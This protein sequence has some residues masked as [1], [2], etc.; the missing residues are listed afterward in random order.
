MPTSP[1]N[2]RYKT[3]EGYHD[4][5]PLYTGT[6]MPL[7]PNLVFN[8]TPTTSE[9][10]AN[11]TSDSEDESEIE[12]VPKQKEYN[13]ILTSK[14]VKTPRASVKPVEH[15]KQ[16]ETLMTD[17]QQSRGHKNSWN[18]KACFV[19]K[20]LNH[21]IKDYD[22]YE[23]QMGNPQQAIKD[24]GVIDNGCSR[25][26]TGNIYFLLD[27]EEINGG[28][29]AFGGNPKGGKI[30]GKGKIKTGKLDFDDV[31]FV[32]ELMFNLFSVSQMCDK[33]NNVLFTNTE[34][35]VLS[36]DYKVPDEN[37]VLLRVPRE[38]NMYNVDLKNVVPSRDLTCLFAK[39]TLDE[40]NIWH[41]RLGHI[42][43]KTMNKLV[44]GNLVRGLPSKIFENHHTCVACKKGRQH[45][46]S[47]IGPK[48]LF[49][50]DTL[51]KSMNY[52]PVVAGNQPNNHA[53][54]KENID[55]G[56][57][58]NNHACIKENI[59]AGKVGKET[60]FAQQY[61][62]LPLWS[63]SSQDPQNID[64][65]AFDV[66]ENENDVYVSPRVRD[67]RAEF[68]DF[69]INRTNM[70]NA[71]SAPVTAVGPTPTNSTNSFNTASPSDTVVS[72]NFRIARESSFVDLSN[73]LD[74]PDMPALE[75][76]VYSEDEEDVSAEADFFN[77]ETNLP[78][79]KKAIGSKWV[80]RKKKDEKWIVIRNKAR[81][82]AQGHTQEEGIDYNE[83]FAL[84][85]RIEA[86][87]LFLAYA[88]FM[89]FM[90]YQ[91]DV[92]S[93]FLYGTIEEVYV[94]QPPGFVDPD[95][96]DK[97]Y[98]EVKALYGLHQAPRA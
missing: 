57:Q 69:S 19:C 22:Y 30:T 14:H 1:V 9:S 66:K 83:V 2:D 64:D 18:R 13:F 71:A 16:A 24:K 23:K 42:N 58:P 43:F 60:T 84:V 52:Q 81:H 86:I 85:A 78:K 7:K 48:W 65:V 63:T 21:L 10:I 55:A 82:V 56:N 32:K 54:I 70:V 45:R 79:G 44:K 73:Y 33:K 31:Y 87:C 37:H 91:M 77:L 26:M 29:V 28:Y 12:C 74:D 4:V 5:A 39:A 51:N 97:V 27:F 11:V 72:P 68:E 3:G 36:S 53:C 62:L 49:D 92:K 75:D 20:S 41:R 6:F 50:I 98:K 46:A 40:S 15:P 95:Y 67:L 89:G 59:D 17:N 90:V 38:N 34:C 61:V 80:F 35:V 8:D 76:I 96:P 25:H 88:S 47:W 93:A 94:C